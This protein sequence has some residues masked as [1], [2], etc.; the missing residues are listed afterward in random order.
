MLGKGAS[1]LLCG[2]LAG[3]LG[4]GVGGVQLG[5]APGSEAANAVLADEL[6]IDEFATKHLKSWF[7]NRAL[8]DVFLSVEGVA[9]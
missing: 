4:N 9:A 6:D 5:L 3:R 7:F 2:F 8:P 1:G